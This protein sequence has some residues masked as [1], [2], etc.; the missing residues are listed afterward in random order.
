MQTTSF[1]EFDV[2]PDP[3]IP[4]TVERIKTVRRDWEMLAVQQRPGDLTMN[5]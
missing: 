1:R 2:R 3:T 4:Q 5:R